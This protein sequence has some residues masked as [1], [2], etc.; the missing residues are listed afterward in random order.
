LPL[1]DHTGSFSPAPVFVIFVPATQMSPCAE[2][3]TCI[4]SGDQDGWMG[5]N[6]LALDIVP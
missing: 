4:P 3:T 1:T 5:M 2:Y 6:A